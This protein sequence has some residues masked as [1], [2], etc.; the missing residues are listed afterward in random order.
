MHT[1]LL[2]GVATPHIIGQSA[3]RLLP[4][5]GSRG[6]VTDGPPPSDLDLHT[7]FDTDQAVVARGGLKMSRRAQKQARKVADPF[8]VKAVHM[9]DT[10][11]VDITVQVGV[12]GGCWPAGQLLGMCD[13][14]RES[15]APLQDALL[16]AH[17][18]L[19]QQQG[20]TCW[21]NVSF[22]CRVA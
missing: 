13:H 11:P 16:T 2:F 1:G 14:G 3:A 4:L 18:P 6:S 12:G 17:A 21:P 22:S 5:L 8:T 9:G 10:Q 7:L 15:S 20:W 19:W